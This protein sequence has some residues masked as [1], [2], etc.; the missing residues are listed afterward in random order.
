M[1]CDILTTTPVVA[2]FPFAGASG[3]A[4]C[5]VKL[6]GADVAL[7]GAESWGASVVLCGGDR[8]PCG[9]DGALELAGSCVQ[10]ARL[11]GQKQPSPR[12]FVGTRTP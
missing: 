3:V 12:D 8:V 5:K 9:E 10:P 1:K 2:C 7:A 4:L 6:T 11:P